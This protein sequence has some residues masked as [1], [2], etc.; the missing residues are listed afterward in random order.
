MKQIQLLV[1]SILI[2]TW[3]ACVSFAEAQ[4]W[5]Y[6]TLLE[7]GASQP[8][9]SWRTSDGMV[10]AVG[11]KF[12]LALTGE[13]LPQGDDLFVAVLTHLGSQRWELV[14]TQNSQRYETVRYI[15][16]RPQR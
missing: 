2:F 13:R 15:F 16:K 8:D 4:T 14:T 9:F 10:D 7:F 3:F 6:A 12:Y 11:S 1:S 5:E